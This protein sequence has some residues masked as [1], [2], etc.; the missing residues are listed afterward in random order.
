MLQRLANRISREMMQ[1]DDHSIK[2][3]GGYYNSQY[4][5]DGAQIDDEDYDSYSGSGQEPMAGSGYDHYDPPMKPSKR[6][7]MPLVYMPHVKSGFIVLF[8]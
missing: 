5:G 8:M 1:A 6:K 7:Y 3:R 4:S 2:Y